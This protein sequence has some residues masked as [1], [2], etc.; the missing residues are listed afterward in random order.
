LMRVE[1]REFTW[2]FSQLSSTL[3][4]TLVLVWPRHESWENSHAIFRLRTLVLGL[5]LQIQLTFIFR[6]IPLPARTETAVYFITI[7]VFLAY[8][9]LRKTK[10]TKGREQHYHMQS[11]ATVHGNQVLTSRSLVCVFN[12]SLLELLVI[13]YQGQLNS[14]VIK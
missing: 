14:Y 7:R 10:M 13:S 11:S 9:F 1:K 3:N 8:C 4:A 2:E 12:S 6:T 5:K